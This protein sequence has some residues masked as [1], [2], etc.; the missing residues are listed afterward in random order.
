MKIDKKMV[1][2]FLSGCNS[3]K[4][5]GFS[6]IEILVAMVLIMIMVLAFTPLLY[7]SIER[8]Y[9]SGHRSQAISEA[10]GEVE[11]R[12]YS[13]D[14]VDSIILDFTISEEVFDVRGGIVDVE[15]EVADG[16]SE[17]TALSP[18]VPTILLNPSR[19]IEG[20]KE[21]D[22]NSVNIEVSGY[23]TLFNE[24]SSL[25]ITGDD[26]S[27]LSGFCSQFT[28]I[29]EAEAEIT[30]NLGL[31]NANSPYTFI[32]ETDDE[33][34]KGRLHVDLPNFLAVG[35][36]ST[37]LASNYS[38]NWV[39]SPPIL[40]DSVSINSISWQKAQY[41]AV[42]NEGLVISLKNREPWV[43]ES[44][45]TTVSLNDIKWGEIQES[46]QYIIA[47]NNGTLLSSSS[48][49]VWYAH[50]SGSSDDLNS[51][52]VGNE[53]VVAV[54]DN[55]T[56]IQSKDIMQWD[57]V[58]VG[59]DVGA[60]DLNDV[61][62][63]DGI[64]EGANSYFIAVGNSGSVYIATEGEGILSW[65]HVEGVV[66]SYDLHSVT[67][68]S[69]LIVIVGENGSI[70]T[71]ADSENWVSQNS[72]VDNSLNEVLYVLEEDDADPIELFISVGNLGTIITSVD[73]IVWDVMTVPTNNNLYG[74][75]C[76]Y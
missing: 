64:D 65:S 2:N 24:T 76:R 70:M 75:G 72:N 20:Y 30:L 67:V 68:G 35:V 54:G 10:Q 53:T 43:I 15:K 61:A 21:P 52:A 71:S 33:I 25:S 62:Y 31:K 38:E 8:I 12:L 63:I 11:E 42:G 19:L 29:A 55:G 9:Y 45:N 16:K 32:I 7:H 5:A 14:V 60:D 23:N 6:L 48:G 27:N 59:A 69:N 26:G 22:S 4:N 46:S 36:S 39:D 44:S 56:I 13:K 28:V 1:K 74:V 58:L 57:K 41:I 73:G 37:I 3:K 40:P 18:L 66:T 49:S 47:G 51:V 17:L 50:D 34:T